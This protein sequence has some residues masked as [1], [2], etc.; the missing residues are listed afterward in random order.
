MNQFDQLKSEIAA[1][2][3]SIFG[4]INTL[5]ASAEDD[6][7]KYYSKGV[8][9]AGNRLKKKMQEIRKAIKHP[10]VKAQMSQIQNSAKDLRQSLTDE[11]STKVTA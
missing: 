3:D 9:S 6:A 11:I 10:A 7:D 5:I 8:K 2:Q 1:A 4:P